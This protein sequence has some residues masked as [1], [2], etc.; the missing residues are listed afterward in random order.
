MQQDQRGAACKGIIKL[1]KV[2]GNPLT[3]SCVPILF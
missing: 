3:I 2:G 1:A